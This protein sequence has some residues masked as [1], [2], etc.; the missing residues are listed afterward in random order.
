MNK[1][2]ILD[3]LNE[4]KKFIYPVLMLVAGLFSGVIL[5]KYANESFSKAISE[6]FTI[7]EAPFINR[8]INNLS[9]YFSIYFLTILLGL[10]LI[11]F[12]IL[13]I[14]P[15]LIGVEL[16]IKLSY[17]YVTYNVKGVAYSALMIAPEAAAYTTILVFAIVNSNALSKNIYDLISKKEGTTEEINL[18][19]YL[20]YFLV[21]AVIIVF[22]SLINSGCS[23]LL[24]SIIRI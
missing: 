22:I 23:Y 17:F 10:C 13:N 1:N 6:L 11:G 2:K 12:P 5:Y 18:K 20:K 8:F 21:Y 7:N 9:L 4:H 15:L 14:I 19:S 24:S 16:A 3:L